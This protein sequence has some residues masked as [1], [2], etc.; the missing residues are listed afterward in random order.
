MLI[1]VDCLGRRIWRQLSAIEEGF[2]S[3]HAD[4]S[5]E[6]LALYQLEGRLP[7]L[8]TDQGAIIEVE[9]L[10]GV[11]GRFRQPRNFKRDEELIS[12]AATLDSVKKIVGQLQTVLRDAETKS[13]TQSSLFP[14]KTD[15]NFYK[16]IPRTNRKSL[17][18]PSEASPR[19][20]G[21][22]NQKQM[23]YL[24]GT[25]DRLDHQRGSAYVTRGSAF[26]TSRWCH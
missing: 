2:G 17:D 25:E 23:E 7:C 5:Y 16:R 9:L 24:E 11:T 3:I 6:E 4:I 10:P 1:A 12:S 18:F 15:K 13:S 26:R 19:L 22:P 21:S 8:R 14:E 20:N